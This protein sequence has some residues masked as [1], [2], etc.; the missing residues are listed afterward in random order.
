MK[1]KVLVR[2]PVLTRTGYG[3]HG[4][5]VLRALRTKED[6]LDIHLLPINWGQSGWIYNDDEERRW[7]DN[8]IQ[9]TVNYQQSGNAHYDL[10]IQVTI[11]NEWERFA[12]V[13]IGVTAGI[14]TTKVA[15]EWLERA[16]TMDKVI[17]IST[18]SKETFLNSVY[19]AVHKETGQRLQMKC[20]TDIDIVHYPVK[21]F[22]DVN[23][24][25]NLDTDFNFLT[26]AQW[27]PR[28]NLENTI[29]WF[30]E[31]FIDQEVGLVVKSFAK[32]NSIIDRYNAISKLTN[33]LSQYKNR[34]CKV[35][36]LHGDLTD[37]EIHSLYIHPQIKAYV[38]LSHGEGFGLPH[39]E[40][41]YSGLPVIAPDWSGYLDFLCKPTKGKRGNIKN[42]PHFARVHY[43]LQPVQKE[44][45]WDGVIQEDSMWCYADQGSYKMNLREVYKDYKRFKSQ[46]NKLQKWVS[47][48]FKAES[49]YTLFVDCL[50]EFLPTSDDLEWE[51]QLSEIKVI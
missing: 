51:K 30:V 1:T 33:I 17:T 4:R 8:L 26:I 14:E 23:L 19:D 46:A 27:G 12:P 21:K 42:K 29:K 38:S 25:L 5:F 45:V 18:H 20:N 2:A 7:I 15:P 49:Q 28:K 50:N 43:S 41:A 16:N 9:K 40:A 22:D 36:L 39:F 35:Y 6:V 11:P 37:E 44:S 47:K 3:E 10:S 32:G 48:E 24:D 34:K 13:N 31:E